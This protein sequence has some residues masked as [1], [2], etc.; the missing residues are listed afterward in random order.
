MRSY[1][2]AALIMA[3]CL[4]TPALAQ[5]PAPAEAP[6][7]VE[8]AAP[9]APPALPEIA[10]APTA[11]PAP[12]KPSVNE[13]AITDY[14]TQLLSFR[15]RIDVMT[16]RIERAEMRV[17]ALKTSALSG[18][19][20]RTRAIISHLSEAGNG[21]TVERATYILDGQTIFD[22]EN[23]DGRLDEGEPLQLFSGPIGPGDHELKV[24]VRMRGQAYGPFTYLEGYKFNIQSR[25]TFQVAEGQLNRL[26][27][28]TTQKPDLTLE[29]QD[30]LTVRYDASIVDPAQ[31][32]AAAQ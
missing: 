13:A 10:P 29:P 2:S 22:R 24:A 14:R 4:G 30:R 3:L 17:N 8:E 7:P 27:V 11:A 15:E 25:Y 31:A 18:V 26:D 28:V 20:V 32:P 9:E 6:A 5:D 1:S 19:V 23:T 21:F 16:K 12:A